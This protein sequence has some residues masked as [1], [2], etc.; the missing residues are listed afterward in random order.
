[1]IQALAAGQ[2]L[3]ALSRKPFGG[4]V[5]LHDV[6]M[7]RPASRAGRLKFTA[8]LAA[9]ARPALALMLAAG[10][11]AS[12]AACESED[13]GNGEK[14]GERVIPFGQPVPK[15]GGIYSVGKPYQVAGVTYHPREDPAYNRVGMASWYGELFHGRR[16]ANGE[17]Y[18]MDRLS[19]AHP[20]L[21]LPVYA[22][23]TNLNN[24]RSI[25]VRIND[26]G[27]FANDRIIDLSKRSAEV[28]GFRRNG[29]ATVRVTYLRRAPLNGDDGYE[30]RYLAGQ[31]F[32]QVAAKGQPGASQRRAALAPAEAP[33]IMASLPDKTASKSSKVESKPVKAAS[34]PDKTASKPSETTSQPNETTSQPSETASKPVEET[35]RSPAPPEEPESSETISLD[36]I[37]K[38][39][40]PVSPTPMTL[41]PP[42]AAPT[43]SASS[44][45]ETSGVLIQAGMFKVQENVD[46]ARSALSAIAPVEV[47]QVEFR[48]DVLSR[49]RVGP[50]P[51]KEAARAALKQVTQAGYRGAK[52][53]D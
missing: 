39:L 18:D 1:V 34:L 51:D 32:M 12:L 10:L 45:G 8:G 23:V 17:I 21:P 19:A 3:A 9:S 50:F 4:S 40:G 52:I 25:V 5:D 41:A 26:R 35:A 46:N 24:G 16:T 30:Q 53:V 31:S 49:V 6:I 47:T 48:G 2:A 11:A 20:T 15:G 14:L 27:P 7:R 28:L 33:K 29:T 36:R 44:A 43:A 22:R 13:G 38:A 37:A 42:E